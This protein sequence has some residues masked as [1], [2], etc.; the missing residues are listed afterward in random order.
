MLSL[1]RATLDWVVVAAGMGVETERD[2]THD[3]LCRAFD[4]GPAAP[5]LYLVEGVI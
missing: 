1:D 5:G 4:R 3:A 2:D